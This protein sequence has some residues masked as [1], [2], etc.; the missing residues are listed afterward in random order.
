MMD[1]Y[2]QKRI[3]ELY[4]D[5]KLLMDKYGMKPRTI[6]ERY[7]ERLQKKADAQLLLSATPKPRFKLPKL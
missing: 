1:P 2:T 6:E 4:A 7:Q 5:M 3:D